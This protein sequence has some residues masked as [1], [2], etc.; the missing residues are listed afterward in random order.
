MEMETI[1]HTI[2][3]NQREIIEEQQY[4]FNNNLETDCVLISAQ[5][6]HIQAHQVVLSSSSD[7]FRT[8]L[9]DSP[10]VVGSPTIHIPDADTC[11][12]EAMLRFIY[13]GETT[14]TSD[15]FSALIAI[16]NLLHIKGCIANGFTVNGAYMK[17]DSSIIEKYNRSSESCSS[18]EYLMVT[19]AESANS[20]DDTVESYY[21]EEY[22]DDEGPTD[23][24]KED[25]TI[26]EHE[27][28][29]TREDDDVVSD[30]IGF[31]IENSTEEIETLALKSCA[32]NPQ[33]YFK[34]QRNVSRQA[35]TRSSNSQ[36]DKA[37]NEVS[38]GKTIHR[39]S[40]EYN[41]PRSTL[42]HRF[43]NNENLRQNYRLERKSALDSAVRAVLHERLS[44]KIAADRFKVPKTAIWR[45]VRKYE[46]YQP[47]NKEITA[48]R[49][50]AQS[51]ILSGKS[52]TSISAKYGKNK[53]YIFVNL[54]IY[55]FIL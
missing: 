8:I 19:Q 55:S 11:V 1:H 51:E 5:G 32:E 28:D 31:E 15:H 53:T 37:L 6:K 12:L 26:I 16:C 24:V 34:R 23:V 46:Q 45:E 2:K 10:S 43:R 9:S 44:L 27:D 50:N 54:F 42:Y 14:I 17:T 35:S 41:L 52:L 47:A 4:L 18:E 48:E 22:L 3:W 25:Q 20:E 7:F 39:L 30:F 40:V 36:I 49:Q 29:E 38:N 33:Q 13:T 21:F